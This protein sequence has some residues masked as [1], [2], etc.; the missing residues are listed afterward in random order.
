MAVGA[1]AGGGDVSDPSFL[2]LIERLHGRLRE[3]RR[4]PSQPPPPEP[5]ATVGQ[6]QRLEQESLLRMAQDEPPV[7]SAQ[8]LQTPAG[9]AEVAPSIPEMDDAEDTEE[10]QEEHADEALF[11]GI[12]ERE[13]DRLVEWRGGIMCEECRTL[14]RGH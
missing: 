5:V 11:C 8:P 2:A 12:C 14:L 9:V 6:D 7:E 4:A 10:E 13:V 1:G 3:V